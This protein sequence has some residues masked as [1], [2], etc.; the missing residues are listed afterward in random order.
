M[1]A[2]LVIFTILACVVADG[3]VVSMRNRKLAI[4]G[5]RVVPIPEMV[6]SQDGGTPIQEDADSVE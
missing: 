5:P 1:V 2:L 6:F 4:A 3:I